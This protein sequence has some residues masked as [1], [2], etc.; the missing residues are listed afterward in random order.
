MLF[1]RTP[2]PHIK[3]S[4]NVQDM[5]LK[6]L[7]ALIPG[8]LASIY[9]FGWGVLF[10]LLIAISVCLLSEAVILKVRQRDVTDSLMDGS[11]LVTACLL[12]LALP[13]LAPWWLTV[14]AS[15]SAI[16]VAKHLYGGLG[17]NPFNPAMVGYIVVMISFP[18]EMT[19]WTAPM[20][21][22]H[23]S[24]T[25]WPDFIT[26]FNWVFL[27][28]LPYA[29]TID[30]ISMATPIDLLKTQ[31]SQFHDVTETRNNPDFSPLFSSISG[32]GWQ[33][34]NI[35]YLAGGVW[36][37]KKGVADWRIPTAFLI[38]LVLISNLFAVIDYSANSSA[39]FHAFSGGTML[40]AF[41]IATDPVS[42]STTPRGRWIY[43]A[44]IGALVYIIRSWGGYPD[45]I[46]FAVVLMNIAAPLID[47]YTQ[48]KVYGDPN[49]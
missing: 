17:F 23:G 28:A 46:A 31:L 48:P 32:T 20:G 44:G 45:G 16:A 11:A 22:P 10:N 8:A 43:G 38:S 24:T 36:L 12:A 5:M 27:G 49:R 4:I 47:Y 35:L 33:W 13:S 9:F 2:A 14:I 25:G 34:I 26:T 15:I 1:K 29:E 21:V 39:L 6:V 30:S 41:F 40:C 19:L 7:Y 3:Q 37:V 42:A 18:L